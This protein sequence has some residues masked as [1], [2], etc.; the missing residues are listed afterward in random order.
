[1]TK[2]DEITK[3]NIIIGIATFAIIAIAIIAAF[4]F[5]IPKSHA[6]ALDFEKVAVFARNKAYVESHKG[7]FKQ[8]SSKKENKEVFKMAHFANAF[9]RFASRNKT[10]RS[11]FKADY[12]NAFT[13]AFAKF[14]RA[15]KFPQAKS[16]LKFQNFK[17]GFSFEKETMS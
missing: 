7:V 1:M 6:Q 14:E 17:D 4:N 12:K 10:E 3:N 8:A 5:F 9:D 16:F 13:F 2:K 15:E 11:V